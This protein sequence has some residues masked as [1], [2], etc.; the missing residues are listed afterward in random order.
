MIDEIGIELVPILLGEG[1]RFFDNLG[2]GPIALERTSV[3]TAPG[4][5]HLR[6][7]VVR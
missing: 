7:R 1:R 6:Y 2:L 3:V 4:V 5:T